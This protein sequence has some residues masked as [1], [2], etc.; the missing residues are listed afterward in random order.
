M[1][2]DL[3]LC[4]TRS[5]CAECRWSTPAGCAL[6]TALETAVPANQPPAPPGSPFAWSDA[7]LAFDDGARS[8]A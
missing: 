7:G 3:L 2:P 8:F 6:L 1:T 5:L 4:Q